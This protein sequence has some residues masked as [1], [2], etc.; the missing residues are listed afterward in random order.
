[1]EIVAAFILVALLFAAIGT[2]SRLA[3]GLG[4]I[5]LYSLTA[6]FAAI[7]VFGASYAVSFGAMT[8]GVSLV[9]TLLDHEISGGLVFW[10]LC[11]YAFAVGALLYF[12]TVA[13]KRMFAGGL[14]EAGDI[15]S[16]SAF[17]P[18]AQTAAIVM[19]LLSAT[20]LVFAVGVDTYIRTADYL[21]L[22]R[23]VL[24]SVASML[25]PISSFCVGYAFG[26][27]KTLASRVLTLALGAL[28]IF[29]LLMTA[30][31]GAAVVS[32][33]CATGYLFANRLL[34]SSKAIV[35]MILS[36]LVGLQLLV[37][38]LYLRALPE[39]GLIPYTTALIELATGTASADT[40][41]ADAFDST[42][43][44]LLFGFP[45]SVTVYLDNP[46]GLPFSSL[47]TQLNPLPSFLTNWDE[48]TPDLR[49]NAFTPYSLMG[50]LYSYGHTVAIAFFSALG[51]AFAIL[52]R[53]CNQMLA[54]G[55]RVV[56]LIVVASLMI[57][58]PLAT[59][60]N[61]R[62][63]L[64]PVYYAAALLII[65]KMFDVLRNASGIAATRESRL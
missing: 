20:T 58:I 29:S 35:V 25:F 30:S 52:G 2:L 42:A 17:M 14:P 53:E 37:L 3:T 38:T 10:L 8:M 45:L 22:E 60:Y 62:A 4:Y 5:P 39:H 16:T 55:R 9:V 54:R 19:S 48:L 43:G 1:L 18:S 36:A 57:F 24:K 31:R 28:L 7:G 65:V 56:P 34:A 46:D 41:L 51:F 12:K 13:P 15:V 47:V 63:C 21:T 6:A 33:F 44:N 59:Q 61:M 64:R 26:S 40:S 11:V 32:V 49:L 50:E 23:P 27:A